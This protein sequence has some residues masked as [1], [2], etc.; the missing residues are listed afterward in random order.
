MEGW[1]L[2]DVV[3]AVKPNVL[4]GLSTV[5]DLFTNEIMAFMADNQVYPAKSPLARC[6]AF[7]RP[8]SCPSTCDVG[9][10]LLSSAFLSRRGAGL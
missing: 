4:I 7:P 9:A 8:F 3:K 2:L 1:S 10:A 6:R 5:K